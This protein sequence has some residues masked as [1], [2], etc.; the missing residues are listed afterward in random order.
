MDITFFG[1][2]HFGEPALRALIANG[3]KVSCVV[4]QPDKRK[5][6][7][8]SL[9]HTIIKETAKKFNL[10]IFQP[11]S[12][13]SPDS[14]SRLRNLKPDLFVVLA[15]GQILSEELLNIP[16]IIPI[17]IHGSL[18]P[19]YRGAAPINWAIIK[20]EKL[21]GNTLIKITRQMDAGPVI[22]QKKREILDSDTAASLEGKLAL[23][24]AELLLEGLK[25]IEARKYNLIPQ[26]D[27][28]ASFAP[29]LKRKD[30]LI[31]WNK[32]AGDI[33]NLI[34]GTLDWPSAF[35]YYKGKILKI[36]KAAFI[37]SD[38]RKH[39]ALPGQ[40][41]KI[42]KEA[43]IVATLKGDLIIEE[44]QIEG[45]RKMKAHEF[46]LGHKIIAGEIFG[47]NSCN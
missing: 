41:L 36:C 37:S 35:T 1:S 14:I 2:S 46:V 13:N 15:Y 20:G 22:L 7:S 9:G 6:R 27:K 34:R 23:D 32:P 39:S 25:L 11:V 38:S 16:K 40:I 30:G 19:A 5:G 45:K 4:T 42:C 21:T 26:D 44:L 33:F 12:I 3:Y 31:D 24:A 43:I 29:K 47:K 10:E 8:M 18:L 17:N 28:K